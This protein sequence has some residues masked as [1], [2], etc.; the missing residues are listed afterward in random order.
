MCLT[1]A[2]TIDNHPW[3]SKAVARESDEGRSLRHTRMRTR[4]TPKVHAV[5]D[6]PDVDAE[7]VARVPRGTPN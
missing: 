5:A 1:F 7:S 2:R 6:G 4:H 3:H